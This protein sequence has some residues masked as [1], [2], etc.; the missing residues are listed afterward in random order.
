[1]EPPPSRFRVASGFSSSTS[2]FSSTLV[3]HPGHWKIKASLSS[4][5]Y[6]CIL[7]TGPFEGVL[8]C[9]FLCFKAGSWDLQQLGPGHCV[10]EVSG[11]SL[12]IWGS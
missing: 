8:H 12:L 11:L 7:G 3:F 6:L 4:K 10:P 9:L 2:V 1:M 5:P